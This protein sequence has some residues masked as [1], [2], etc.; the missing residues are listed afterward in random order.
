M[1]LMD[2][3]CL[4]SP[5][6]VVHQLRFCLASMTEQQRPLLHA[7]DILQQGT[8]VHVHPPIENDSNTPFLAEQSVKPCNLMPPLD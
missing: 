4:L 1:G 7:I 2:S 6:D 8:K 3:V 5:A